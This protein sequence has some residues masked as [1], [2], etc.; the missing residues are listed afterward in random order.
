MNICLISPKGET[1]TDKRLLSILE[2]SNDVHGYFQ[3]VNGAFSSGLLI[4]AALTPEKHTIKFIDE[5]I[6]EIDFDEKFDIVGLTGMTQQATRMYELADT[7]RKKGITVVIGGIHATVMPEEAKQYCDSVFVGEAEESWPEFLSDFESG[8]ISAFYKYDK[9]VELKRSPM[10]AYELIQHSKY[11]V[12][13]IQT[14]RGCPH[15][16]EFCGASRV[17][18]KRYR[19][20]SAEQI[21]Q[22]I[23][24]IQELWPDAKINFSDDNLFTD[25]R[26]AVELIKQINKKNIRWFAQSDISIADDEKLLQKMKEAGCT[27]LFIGFESLSDESLKSINKNEWKFKQ[28]SNYKKAILKIQSFGIGIIGAFILGMDGD[29][30]D[31]FEELK[32]FIIAN[33]ICMVQISIMTPLPGTRLYARLSNENRLLQAAW[34]QFTFTEVNYIPK[35]M[36]VE[37]LKEG[38]YSLYNTVYSPELRFKVLRH[39]KE[40]F[41]QSQLVK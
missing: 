4:I 18:G 5:N 40:I 36:T 27:T 33:N 31:S 41:K 13:W 8:K 19:H 25:R 6:E 28:R 17:Y 21:S 24:K 37:E 7:F 2:K 26:Y 30:S 15:D 1:T 16:C 11:K 10:P 3:S 9:T 39:F 38:L 34:S 35:N 29:T 32:N 20:K 12:I 22:E 23:D 14:S